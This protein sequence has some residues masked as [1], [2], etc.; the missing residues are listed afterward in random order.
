MSRVDLGKPE[1]A[2]DVYDP[3][4]QRYIRHLDR[5]GYREIVEILRELGVNH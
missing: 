4:T 1:E 2:L 5:E 3:A